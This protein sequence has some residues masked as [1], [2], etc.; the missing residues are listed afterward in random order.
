MRL[1]QTDKA[2]DGGQIADMTIELNW[3]LNPN[4]KIQGNYLLVNRQGQQ[5]QG[6]GW[7]NGLGI[8]AACDF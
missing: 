3:F 4:M 1:P 6:D 5:G 7:F 2:I 8:R